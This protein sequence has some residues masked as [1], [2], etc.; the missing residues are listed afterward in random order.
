MKSNQWLT[1]GSHL[2][3]KKWCDASD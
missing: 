1:L 2:I 3:L